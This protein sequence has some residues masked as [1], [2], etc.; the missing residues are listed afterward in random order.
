MSS[1]VCPACGATTAAGKFCATCG[2][3]LTSG[4]C[5]SC[6]ASL[7]PGARFC[8]RC[9]DPVAGTVPR[10]AERTAWLVAG[11]LSL[12]L[13]AVIIA[14]MIRGARPAPPPD[15]ANPGSAGGELLAG[16][17]PDISNMTPEEQY[18][19]LFE[20]VT[21]AAQEGDSAQVVAFAPMALGAYERLPAP[22]NDDRFHAAML[23]FMVGDFDGS[24]ALADTLERDVPEHLF[25][26]LIRA[27]IALARGDTA[28]LLEQYRVFLR[29]YPGEANAGRQEYQD[30][31]DM[32]SQFKASADS[33][34]ARGS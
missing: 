9:G 22:G 21:R 33:A 20:R 13:V 8:H 32:L 31:A 30:H 15:M 12:V 5:Q 4:R 16:P 17:A 18:T 28:A 3:P 6:G 14:V 7:T 1:Q 11:G 24:L 19:R 10:R 2:S 23:H 34:T 26:P 29:R 25:A 27:T